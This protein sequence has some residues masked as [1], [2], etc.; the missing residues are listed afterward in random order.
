MIRYYNFSDI[1]VYLMY[2]KSISAA[3]WILYLDH[4]K[5]NHQVACIN[6]VNSKYQQGQELNKIAEETPGTLNKNKSIK[7]TKSRMM[8]NR[9]GKKL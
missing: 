6:M 2:G 7:S 9:K 8:S 3:K 4:E 1:C 5:Q